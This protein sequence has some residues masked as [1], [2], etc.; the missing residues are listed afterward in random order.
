MEAAHMQK[1]NL[2]PIGEDDRAIL[3]ARMDRLPA[4]RTIWKLVILISLGGFFEFYELFSTAYVIPGIV[5][6]GI[7]KETSASFLAFD[8]I[9]GYIAATF[10]GLF[11]GTFIFGFIA[12]KCG[13]RAVFTY[14]LLWYCACA[15]IT[16]LQTDATGLNLW[17]ML[18]GIGLGVELVTM[19][20]YLSELVPPQVRGRAFAVNQAITY[21]AVPVVGL[22]AWLLVPLAPFGIDGWRLVL[23][24]GATGAVAVW[25]IRYGLPESPR[26]LASVG[27]IEQA[28]EIVDKIEHRVVIENG[29]PLDLP[30]LHRLDHSRG[31]FAEIWSGKYTRRT[32]MLLLFHVAQ[33]VGLYGFSNWVP[34]FLMHQGVQLAHSLQYTL[35]IAL[36]TPLGPLVALAFADRIER[37]WQIV[38]A[39]V[40]VALAGLG[41]AQVRAAGAIILCG[42]LVTLG[43]TIM[44]LNFHAYQSELYPTRVRA[45]AIGFVYSASR[46]SGIFSGFLIS[47]ALASGGVSSALTLIAGCMGV[48]AVSVG[49]LGPRTRGQSLEAL[50]GED[51]PAAADEPAR[52]DD[53]PILA[54]ARSK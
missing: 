20:A 21:S 5:R 8:G 52:T 13:R 47:F 2:P 42:S 32:I 14:S 33:S 31:R 27:R 16:A 17:R 51:E 19:D 54:S 35:F 12:D 26:W 45:L 43:A 24:I 50:T 10:A 36:V 30:V 25:A 44:S 37:K 9:A 28:K 23:L 11:I 15:S 38:G 53:L 1:Q 6:S 7:L 34:T 4:T 46:V 39:A 22:L 3:A 18:T 29:K 41:F 48:V 49:V 40:L